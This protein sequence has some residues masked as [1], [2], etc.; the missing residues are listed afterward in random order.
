MK[1]SVRIKMKKLAR[2]ARL[3]RLIAFIGLLIESFGSLF[4][5][6]AARAARVTPPRIEC[7]ATRAAIVH[8][9][10]EPTR[11]ERAEEKNGDEDDDAE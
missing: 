6:I 4:E 5:R 8:R 3:E 10:R 11:D 9:A 7:A 1:V 2:Q